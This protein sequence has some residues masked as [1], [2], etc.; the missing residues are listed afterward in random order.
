[1][2][3]RFK[4]WLDESGDFKDEGK[5]KKWNPSLVGG[6]LCDAEALNKNIVEEI[7][8][9]K[10]FHA[11]ENNS[12]K[13]NIEIL[14]QV[15]ENNCRLVVFENVKKINIVDSDI[16]YINIFAEGLVKLIQKLLSENSAIEI[17]IVKAR[18]KFVEH[19]SETNLITKEEYLYRI[20]ERI[21]L[22]LIKL[23]IDKSKI[24]WDLE[25]GDARYDK[26]LMISDAIC[27]TYNTRTA[28]KFKDYKDQLKKIIDN[29]ETISVLCNNSEDAIK[30]LIIKDNITDAILEYVSNENIYGNKGIQELI[31]NRING[32]NPEL[33]KSQLNILGEKIELLVNQ[34]REF[35]LSEVILERLNKEFIDSLEETVINTKELRY[36]ILIGLVSLYTHRGEGEKAKQYV[37]TIEEFIKCTTINEEDMDR[38]IR[39]KNK[40]AVLLNDEFDYFGSIKLLDELISVVEENQKAVASRSAKLLGREVALD[41]DNGNEVLGK[42]LGTRLQAR[43]FASR[44]DK[45]EL[46]Q[47]ILDSD[48]A[49]SIFKNTTGYF[50]HLQYRVELETEAGN[51]DEALKI[52][53]KSISKS[54]SE[55][56]SI[57][58]VVENMVNNG[59]IDEFSLMHYCRL[60]GEAAIAESPIANQMF[61]ALKK[62]IDDIDLFKEEINEKSKNN[63]PLEIIHWK[64]ATYYAVNNKNR[65]AL[66]N[67]NKAIKRI[68]YSEK[69]EVRESIGL[70]ILCEKAHYMK[71]AGNSFKDEYKKTLDDIEERKKSLLEAKSLGI[72]LFVEEY[73]NDYENN[74]FDASRK[75]AY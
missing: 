16:T 45:K 26:R 73:F 47:A 20:E 59:E 62:K 36:Q 23:G 32:L 10:S 56:L 38:I 61:R 13:R 25:L 39:V 34:E 42:L 2:A 11:T 41:Q 50:R 12:V 65:E 5:A 64:L 30:E 72:S 71:I 55:E 58:T 28:W 60:M 14:N 6:V 27:N 29:Y 8:V 54:D 52:L 57:E 74:L 1:M 35:D 17:D 66:K 51:Y 49:I 68:K 37:E 3:K 24:K 46:N 69:S 44:I 63:H 22:W 75:V 40:L 67:Y 48:R 33:V 9:E 18:R 21:T 53:A 4:L 43:K 15:L 19:E 31:I 7:I 70:A